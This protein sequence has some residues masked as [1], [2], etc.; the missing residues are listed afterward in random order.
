[1]Q[2]ECDVTHAASIERAFASVHEVFGG[3]HYGFVN[4]GIS[5]VGSFLN[6]PAAEWDG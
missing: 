6:M 1:M 2:I 3:L 5:G 4:A